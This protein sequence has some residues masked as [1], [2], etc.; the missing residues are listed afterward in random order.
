[1]SNFCQGSGKTFRL[2]CKYISHGS[3]WWGDQ[4]DD[5]VECGVGKFDFEI[6]LSVLYPVHEDNKWGSSSHKRWPMTPKLATAEGWPILKGYCNDCTPYW[7]N[8]GKGLD[9]KEKEIRWFNRSSYFINERWGMMWFNFGNEVGHF[10]WSGNPQTVWNL[11]QWPWS[12][13]KK[14]RWAVLSALMSVRCISNS[15]LAGLFDKGQDDAG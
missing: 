8:R 6:P 11:E 14:G 5:T 12:I 1:M 7:C 2:G 10:A 9:E 13:Q 15:T 4:W 3:V